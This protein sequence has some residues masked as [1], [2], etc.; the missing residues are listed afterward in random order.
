[1]IRSFI[2]TSLLDWD[3]KITSVLFFDRC[4]FRCPFCQNWELLLHPENFPAFA[5][6]EILERLKAKRDWIDGVVLTGGEPLLF[7]QTVFKLAR[8]IKDMGF[9]LKI[10]TNGSFP[11]RLLRLIE[12]GVIDYVAMDIKAPL[13]RY[14]D[15]TGKVSK[16]KIMEKIRRSIK[17]LLGGR[18]DYEFR[19]TCVPDFID[20]DSIRKIG[21]E[22]RGAKAWFLQRFISANAYEERLRGREYPLEELKVLL[23]IARQYVPNSRLR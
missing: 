11:E 5:E 3:G 21:E 10:D 23:D 6:N 16:L 7:F 13:D 17:L 1:M 20:K 15:V 22:I 4:N 19:T 14:F 8:K 18:L 12:E 9:L 2:E